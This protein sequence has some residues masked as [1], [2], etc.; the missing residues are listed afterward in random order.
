MVQSGDYF[1]FAIAPNQRVTAFRS[2]IGQGALAG[3]IA[4]MQRIREST[5]TECQYQRTLVQFRRHPS[6]PGHM[7]E[8]G[9]CDNLD[10]LDLIQDRLEM[11]PGN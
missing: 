1:F 2:E 3:L 9:C 8:W 11:N 6:P 10:Y 5:T 7:L 4:N